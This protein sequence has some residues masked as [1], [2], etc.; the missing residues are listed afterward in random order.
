MPGHVIYLNCINCG[1]ETTN[2]KFCGRS[3]SAT[4]NNIKHPKRMAGK[5]CKLCSFPIPAR[6]TYC[7]E[8]CNNRSRSLKSLDDWSKVTLGEMKKDGNANGCRY[9]YIRQL[10]RKAYLLSNK[11]KCCIVCGYDKHFDVAH[12]RDIKSFEEH[13]PVSEVNSL[14]NLTAL[15]KNHHWEYDH[16]DL[17]LSIYITD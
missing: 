8:E 9:P 1:K 4:Y 16:G 6:L 5:K 13:T 12:I 11:P 7:S 10:S 2:P 3:C 15:C 14:S 17:D